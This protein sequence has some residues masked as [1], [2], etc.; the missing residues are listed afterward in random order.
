MQPEVLS[1]FSDQFGHKNG[2]AWITHNG[3]IHRQIIEIRS[4]EFFLGSHHR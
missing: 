4:K 1:K 3:K 2:K